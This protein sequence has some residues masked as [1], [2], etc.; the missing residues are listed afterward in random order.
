MPEVL[1]LVLSLGAGAVLGMIYFGG[2]WHT[3]RKLAGTQKPVS[4]M[5]WSFAVRT[6]IVMTGF[7][8]VM[9]GRWERL[10]AALLGFLLI[11]EVL[12]RRIGARPVIQ[13][14]GA[15]HGNRGH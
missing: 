1:P 2:L 12:I 9:G 4:T 14:T 11:R 6:G 7:Y 10:V 5:L 13:P 8:F 3:V 15:V